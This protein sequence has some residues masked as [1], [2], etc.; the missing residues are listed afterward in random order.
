VCILYRQPSPSDARRIVLWS[1]T[2]ALPPVIELLRP[3]HRSDAARVA[4]HSSGITQG[5]HLETMG[6]WSGAAAEEGE[7]QHRQAVGVVGLVSSAADCM[8]RQEK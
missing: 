2:G 6:E 7:S 8:L 5:G 4:G 1:R 3:R